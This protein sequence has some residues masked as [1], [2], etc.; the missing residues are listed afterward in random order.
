[1]QARPEDIILNSERWQMEGAWAWTYEK[2][3]SGG[4]LQNLL[5]PDY[6]Y[7]E[8]E[9]IYFRDPEGNRVSISVNK[10]PLT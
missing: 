4:Q 6:R 2:I 9:Y 10:N 8:R 7:T 1:M 5:T 3:V